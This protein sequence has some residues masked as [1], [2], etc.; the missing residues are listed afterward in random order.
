MANE[1]PLNAESPKPR[2][3]DAR[4]SRAELLEVATREFAEKGLAGARVEEI[5]SRTATSK[6]MI[7]YHFGSKDGLYRAVLEHA[8]AEFRL[9]E[10]ASNYENMPPSEALQSLV[11]A[12]FDIHAQHPEIVRIIMAEN[13]NHGE[14][15]GQLDSFEHRS[16]ALDTLR[17]I[18]ERGEAD[19]SLCGGLDA[20]QIHLSISALCFHYISNIY[21]YG[22]IFEIAAHEPQQMRKRRAEVIETIFQ[23]CALL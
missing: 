2:R 4:A 6:H 11:G 19:G 18:L 1:R 13:I 8:Y 17:N 5:A 9:A 21:T 23:R 7:Y 3:R 20:L 22:H 12:T 10:G 16:L 14:H 15:I